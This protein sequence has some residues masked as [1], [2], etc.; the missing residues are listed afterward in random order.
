MRKSVFISIKFN[1]LFLLLLFTAAANAQKLPNVQQT[2]LR[3][4]ADIKIDG[5][6]TEWGD[7]FQAYNH[8]TDVFYA[9]SNDD[10]N[11]YLTIQATDYSIINHIKNGGISLTIS[12][13]GKKIIKD[14][15]RVTYPEFDKNGKPTITSK[16]LFETRSGSPVTVKQA[17]SLALVNTKNWNDKSKLIRVSGIKGIDSLISVYNEDGI[18]A[19]VAF[20]NQFACTYELAVNLKL[21]GLSISNPE[22]FA[23]N[24]MLNDVAGHGIVITKDDSGN[25]TTVNI[26]S[27]DAVP[28]EPATDFWGEYTLVKK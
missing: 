27:K 8:A 25:I 18:K 15:M 12:T 14:G 22:K 9:L 10:N 17:D 11:L 21:L 26:I 28:E 5:K 19:A 16:K 24:V 2:S 3:A 7:K 23:Y 13:T 20:N 4:P 6:T 1:I